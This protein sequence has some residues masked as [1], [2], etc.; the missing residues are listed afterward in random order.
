MCSYSNLQA[1]AAD[2]SIVILEENQAS[3]GTVDCA[4]RR[5]NDLSISHHHRD[6]DVFILISLRSGPLVLF[7]SFRTP[8]YDAQVNL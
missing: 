8:V 3:S 5:I 2:I 7:V 4:L 1:Y 6:E